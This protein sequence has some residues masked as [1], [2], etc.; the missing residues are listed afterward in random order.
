MRVVRRW[1]FTIN[2]L[3][4]LAYIDI[5]NLNLEVD[6]RHLLVCS[7]G[8][9]VD[10]LDAKTGEVLMTFSEDGEPTYLSL[11]AAEPM[12]W[13]EDDHPMYEHF[14]TIELKEL[15]KSIHRGQ[16]V[17]MNFAGKNITIDTTGKTIAVFNSKTNKIITRYRY[18]KNKEI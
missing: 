17:S 5:N 9:C 2:T 8:N 3:R 1:V 15:A 12:Q 6:W 13:N 14:A 7:N 18:S 10:V 16:K 4:T 11:W